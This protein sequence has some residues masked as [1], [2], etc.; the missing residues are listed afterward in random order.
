MLPRVASD[1]KAI[2][3]VEVRIAAT[4]PPAL[5]VRKSK[6]RPQMNPAQM[7]GLFLV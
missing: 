7:R 6:W 5:A 3:I 2:V 4:L 1:T